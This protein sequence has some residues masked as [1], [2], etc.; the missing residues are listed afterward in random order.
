MASG[1]LGRNFLHVADCQSLHTSSF[2]SEPRSTAGTGRVLQFCKNPQLVLLRNV[3]LQPPFA[4]TRDVSETRNIGNVLHLIIDE[5]TSTSNLVI[6]IH[7]SQSC[8]TS[9]GIMNQYSLPSIFNLRTTSSNSQACNL[10]VTLPCSQ[11]LITLRHK[12][13]ANTIQSIS[14]GPREHCANIVYVH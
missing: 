11:H 10:R 13:T 3:L 7:T 6:K 1:F 9:T 4:R 2:D 8:F 12:N 5:S 14:I